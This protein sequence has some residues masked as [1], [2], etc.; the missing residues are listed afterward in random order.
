MAAV[1]KP[2]VF[3]ELQVKQLFLLRGMVMMTATVA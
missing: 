3:E 1:T 2:T